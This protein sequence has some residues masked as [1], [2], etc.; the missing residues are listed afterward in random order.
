MLVAQGDKIFNFAIQ[1]MGL[2]ITK[3]QTFIML[4]S[5]DGGRLD[6]RVT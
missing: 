2:K 4:N 6:I 3:N 5:H 1:T